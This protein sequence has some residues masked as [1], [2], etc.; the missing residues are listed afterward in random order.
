MALVTL[1]TDNG[2]TDHYVAAIKAKI[3]STNPDINIVD[4]SH[5]ISASDIGHGAFVLKSVFRDFPKGSVH[6]VGVDAIG[7]AGTLSIALQLE[8]HFFVGADNGLFGL[9]SDRPHQ[10]LVDINSVNPI[11]STF[12]EKDIYAPASAKLASGEAIAS[13]GQPLPSFKKMISRS[14]KATKKLI[15]GNVIRVDHYGNLITNISKTDF[16]ILSKGKKFSIQFSS[17]KAI[18]IHSNYFQADQGDCF[19]VFNHLGLLE[20]GIYRGRA[21]ELLGMEHDSP[22]SITFEEIK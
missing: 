5:K 18:R 9:I 4:I 19:L 3:L 17:E 7:Q 6:L 10:N 15:N 20:I 14:V 13:L 1:L 22:V 16:D 2:D 11:I 8:D 12:P 21:N